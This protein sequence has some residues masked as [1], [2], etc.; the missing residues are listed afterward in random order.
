MLRLEGLR[1]PQDVL[2]EMA[3]Y[4]PAGVLDPAIPLPG[5]ELLNGERFGLQEEAD[6]LRREVG[7]LIHFRLGF[8][9]SSLVTIIM[10]AVLGVVFRGSRALAAFGLGCVPFGTVTILMLMGRQLAE[11]PG[12]E[13]IGA[14]VIWGGLV[15]VALADLIVLRFGVRR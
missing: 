7:S 6:E 11:N 9:S 4:L 1:V 3:L 13:V 5:N 2:E 15:L 8:A 10:G 14:W 12:T